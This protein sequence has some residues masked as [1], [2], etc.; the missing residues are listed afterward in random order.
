MWNFLF[1]TDS[2][3]TKA[4]IS[5]IKTPAK[6]LIFI[7]SIQQDIDLNVAIHNTYFLRVICYVPST[8]LSS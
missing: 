5:R 7:K 3:F 2:S 4:I 1:Q 6:I 8:M